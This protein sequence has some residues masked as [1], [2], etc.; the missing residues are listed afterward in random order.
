M[1]TQYFLRVDREG[2]RVLPAFNRDAAALARAK[3]ARAAFQARLVETFGGY[4]AGECSEPGDADLHMFALLAA[5]EY[6]LERRLVGAPD[7]AGHVTREAVGGAP[8][9]GSRM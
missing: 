3:R 7:S 9:R 8:A 1:S 4:L 2:L 6:R 5:A